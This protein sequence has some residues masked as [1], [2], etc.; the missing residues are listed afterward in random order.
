MSNN[1]ITIELKGRDEDGWYVARANAKH[2]EAE[3]AN[4]ESPYAAACEALASVCPSVDDVGS[5]PKHHDSSD[6]VWME[7]PNGWARASVD[8][9]IDETAWNPASTKGVIYGPALVT[10]ERAPDGGINCRVGV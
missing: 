8:L 10:Y 1:T 5:D 6:L 4:A 2:A 7:R 3:V 9:A